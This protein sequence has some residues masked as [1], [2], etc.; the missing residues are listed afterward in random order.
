MKKFRTSFWGYNKTQINSFVDEVT[1]NYEEM[2]N[3]LKDSKLK[4]AEL[5]DSLSVY[6]NMESSL[7][8]ALL[9]A[10][11][12]SVQIKKIAREEAGLMLNEAKKDASRIIGN[13]LLK[14]EK[15]EADADNLRLK[16]NVYKKRLKQI[17]EEQLESLERFDEDM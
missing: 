14:A 13:A 4:I 1:K 15:T 10:E 6:K 9:V 2:L 8:K 7:N 17:L 11:T 12:S 5:S 16:I 3:S